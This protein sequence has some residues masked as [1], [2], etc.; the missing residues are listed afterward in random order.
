MGKL[1][2]TLKGSTLIEIMIAL[3]ITLF[4]T[5]LAT[6]I[7]L[8]ILNSQNT[9]EKLRAFYVLQKMATT[10]E[11]KSEFLDAE[12]N[13]DT[14][15]IKKTCKPYANNPSLIEL[16]LTARNESGRLICSLNK[17]ILQK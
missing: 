8:N 7:Y 15:V 13:E 16:K 11:I 4:C 3:V 6:L 14:F 5:T 2:L 1:K 12:T 17:I 10:I 9:A